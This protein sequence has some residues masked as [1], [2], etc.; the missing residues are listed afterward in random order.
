MK[1]ILSI[2]AV[3]A[4]VVLTLSDSFGAGAS[5]STLAR[6]TPEVDI[7]SF[8]YGNS[9]VDTIKWVRPAGVS[10]ISVGIY[11]ADTLDV[12]TTSSIVRISNGVATTA[13]AADTLASLEALTCTDYL[14]PTASLDAVT[15]APL[16]QEYWFIFTMHSSANGT[17]T[18][19]TAQFRIYKQYAK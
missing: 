17:G 8:N 12:S 13:I 15:L 5:F 10:G 7:I 6:S 1:K 14:V 2:V 19:N 9:Y 4:L 3:L 18:A 11:V 16:A